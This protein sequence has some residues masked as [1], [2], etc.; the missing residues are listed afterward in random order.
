VWFIDIDNTIA[1]RNIVHFSRYCN[2]L[3]HLGI[4]E[5]RLQRGRISHQTFFSSP[6]LCVFR[7]TL[8][9]EAW[10]TALQQAE[11]APQVL[12]RQRV[13]PSALEGV[14]KLAELAPLTYC[15]VR[16]EEEE[17]CRATVSW[18]A[19]HHF[20]TPRRV[21]FCRSLLHKLV[22]IYRHIQ[23]THESIILIDD[24]FVPL[25]ASFEQLAEGQHP[26][27]SPDQ[28][29][30]IVHVLREKMILIAFQ[31]D[32]V[33]AQC[34]GLQVLPLP[35]WDDLDALLASPDLRSIAF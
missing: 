6:E 5:E 4:P 34:H 33:P 13:L 28:C 7:A 29:Q 16:R 8:S 19:S 11:Q 31:A 15:T 32:T 24:L 35:C 25:L 1:G 14:R 2:T 26:R 10:Q 9:E 23:D 12:A 22:H 18:L 17:V 27:Y 30:Q 21:V 3:W 20:P